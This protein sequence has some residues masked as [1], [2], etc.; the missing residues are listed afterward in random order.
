M[1][2][3]LIKALY[4]LMSE[5]FSTS[6]TEGICQLELTDRKEDNL[7]YVSLTSNR[8]DYHP[9]SVQDPDVSVKMTIE[10]L[11][12]ILQNLDKFDFRHP[13]VRDE[14][15]IQGDENLAFVLFNGIKRLPPDAAEHLKE[16]LVRG[17]NYKHEVTE[18]KRYVNPGRDEF[19]QLMEQG[20]PFVVSGMLDDW[21]FL[22]LDLDEIKRIY[23]KV[24]LRTTVKN[25]EIVDVTTL[26][27]FIDRMDSVDDKVYTQGCSVPQVMC[28]KFKLP[29]LNW[30]H[31]SN[32]LMWMGTKTGDI[33]CTGLHRDCYSNML[34]NLIGRKKLVLF[35]PD[36]TEYVYPSGP[37]NIFQACEVNNVY[38]V[39]LNKYPL[40]KNAKPLEVVIDAGE[41]ILLPAF[42]YHCVY[43]LDDV[44]SV[45]HGI[46]RKAWE[47][48]PVAT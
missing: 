2:K 23:G 19:L 37:F 42:W 20:L 15:F 27:E 26:S 10:M 28:A 13:K 21:E 41:S 33:P 17:S 11:Q 8:L 29:Y 32:P 34:T 24:K 16:V 30:K 22:N 7:A 45:G 5:G 43:A 12:F 39:D 6:D 47:V 3:D 18:I 4:E 14:V 9:G 31:V 25:K 40:F 1:N 44:F 38:D 35:S 46:N 36:Q 48:L